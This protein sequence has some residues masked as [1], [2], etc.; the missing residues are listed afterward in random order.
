MIH[1]KSVLKY[2]IGDE[3]KLSEKNFTLLSKAFIADIEKKYL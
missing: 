1:K 3:S 2:K